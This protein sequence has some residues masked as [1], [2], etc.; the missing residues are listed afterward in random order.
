MRI[1]LVE[2][3][4][5]LGD[6]VREQ[7]LSDG[8]AIDHMLNLK[9]AGACLSTTAY[10]LVLLDMMLPD[11]K[12]L[13]LLQKLRQ[14]KDMTP[15][16]ILTALDQISDRISGL[17]A[18]ADDYLVKPF[19]LAELSARVGAVARRYAG[20]PNPVVTVGDLRIDLAARELRCNDRVVDL[21]PREWSLMEALVQRPN[22]TVSKAS[23][24][25]RLYDL[26]A[27]VESNTVEVHISRL[28][29][30]I[31]RDRIQTVRGIGYRLANGTQP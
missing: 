18:G 20:N 21:T 17:N 6:A 28:R 29:K 22:R 5:Q 31:G 25:N 26:G 3:N 11:G 7:M 12:G 16:I 19:D 30:K 9:D 15:V 1:L 14:K 27:E 2:D 13:V 10:D 24:E 23:L 4:V 8:H